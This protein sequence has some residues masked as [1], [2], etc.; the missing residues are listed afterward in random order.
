M[1]LTRCCTVRYLMGAIRCR[2]LCSRP[3]RCVQVSDLS[4]LRLVVTGIGVSTDRT[5]ILTAQYDRT[6]RYRR[7]LHDVCAPQTSPTQIRRYTL[8]L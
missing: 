3:P 7:R 4:D 1:G 2:S 5:V 6:G 8:I